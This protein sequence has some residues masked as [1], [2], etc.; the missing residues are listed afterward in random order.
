[1]GPRVG[2]MWIYALENRIDADGCNHSN[3][4]LTVV[5]NPTT[6]SRWRWRCRRRERDRFAEVVVF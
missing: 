4:G 1:M 6:S 2:F 5:T 3:Q